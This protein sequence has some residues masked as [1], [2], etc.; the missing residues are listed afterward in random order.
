MQRY[1]VTGDVQ[2]QLG[3][4]KWK[5]NWYLLCVSGHGNGRDCQTLHWIFEYLKNVDRHSREAG[6]HIWTEVYAT[7][8][9]LHYLSHKLANLYFEWR[10][11][12]L[13]WW[14]N[15]PNEVYGKTNGKGYVKTLSDFK[16]FDNIC[17]RLLVNAAWKIVE[18]CD[19]TN[20][21][22]DQGVIQICT[23]W[24]F[25]SYLIILNIYLYAQSV[26]LLLYCLLKVLKYLCD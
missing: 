25:A 15:E 23:Y 10:S 8:W 11:M 14:L 24:I 7:K 26:A 6:H 16:L 18:V 21:M 9:K 22:V 3:N 12:W 1:S 2:D 13:M 19:V 17:C 5:T 20:V 4:I